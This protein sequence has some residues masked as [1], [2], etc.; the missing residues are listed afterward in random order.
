MTP[1]S[2]SDKNNILAVGAHP[3]DIELGAAMTLRG[4][5]LKGDNVYFVICSDGEKGGNASQRIKEMRKSARLIGV[6]KIYRLKNPDSQLN[7]QKL[8]PLLENLFDK[9]HPVRVFF[10]NPYDMH[11]DHAAV[12]KAC[13]I[14]FRKVQNIFM[15]RSPR[16]SVEFAPHVFSSGKKSDFL[17]KQNVLKKYKSQISKGS[18]N[19]QAVEAGALFWGTVGFPYQK[20]VYSEPFLVNHMVYS[21]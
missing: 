14:A 7:S 2:K 16:T 9:I 8:A 1:E 5:I 17:F 19:L 12:A 20:R 6:K 15:Y 21:P 10:H 3:D 13:E 4:H 11:Q 18:I